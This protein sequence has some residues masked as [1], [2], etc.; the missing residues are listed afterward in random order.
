MTRYITF[1]YKDGSTFSSEWDPIL[2]GEWTH[3]KSCYEVIYKLNIDN[4]LYEK[5]D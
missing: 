4:P 5:Y 2:D 3:D 1:E